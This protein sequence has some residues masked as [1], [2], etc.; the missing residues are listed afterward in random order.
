MQ[1][2]VDALDKGLDRLCLAARWLAL[3]L[4]LLLFLQWP[5]RDLVKGWSREANDLGQCVFALY[6]AVSL[7]AAT[8]SGAHL[9]SDALAH[10]HGPRLRRALDAG[11]IVFGLL[12]WSLFLLVV[13]WPALLG[14]LRVLESF[15]D[16]GNPGYFLIRASGFIMAA[17]VFVAGLLA[18][19]RRR[20]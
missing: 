14:S 20:A 9:A 2:I 6:V 17:L 3:P 8:R 19:L 11:L 18:L 16:T 4:V 15:P 1:L 10:R 13:G 5:L 12:P 7:T